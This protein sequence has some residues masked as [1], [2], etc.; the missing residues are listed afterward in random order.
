MA[1]EVDS[2]A[3]TTPSGDARFPEL[4]A[5]PPIGPATSDALWLSLTNPI[6]SRSCEQQ[7]NESKTEETYRP[8][9]TN[10]VSMEMIPC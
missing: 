10:D 1:E 8:L 2:G 3:L 5:K 7:K 9:S 6:I 4:L